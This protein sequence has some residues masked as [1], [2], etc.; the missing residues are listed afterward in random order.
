MCYKVAIRNDY[1][2][3]RC[4]DGSSVHDNILHD[5]NIETLMSILRL[6]L[7]VKSYTRK[8]LL[9]DRIRCFEIEP[10]SF[11]VKRNPFEIEQPNV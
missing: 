5:K 8:N 2:L 1:N 7:F 11:G 6:S 10:L 4:N 3:W 9:M